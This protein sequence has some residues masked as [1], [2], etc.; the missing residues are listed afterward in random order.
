M[1]IPAIVSDVGGL[2]EM[3]NKEVGYTFKPEDTEELTQ[4]IQYLYNDSEQLEKLQKN[5]REYVEK[6][7]SW[8]SV[9]LRYIDTFRSCIDSDDS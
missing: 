2:G 4:I 1:G 7:Y 3:I 8:K 6:N 5:S 9:A